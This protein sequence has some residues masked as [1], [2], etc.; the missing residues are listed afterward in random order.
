MTLVS[1]QEWHPNKR[2]TDHL[3]SDP[4]SLL[5]DAVEENTGPIYQRVI[6]SLVQL[7]AGPVS[8]AECIE[9]SAA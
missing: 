3:I 7:Q 1:Q 6:F 9:E 4:T 8:R 2:L 5:N